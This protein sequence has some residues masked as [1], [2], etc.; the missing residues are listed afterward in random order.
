M[1]YPRKLFFWSCG[2][3]AGSDCALPLTGRLSLL[4]PDQGIEPGPPLKRNIFFQ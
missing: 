2:A 3:T 1:F 4:G